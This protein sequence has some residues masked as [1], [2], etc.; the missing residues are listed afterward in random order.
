MRPDG[1]G[2]QFFDLVEVDWKSDRDNVASAG[3]SSGCTV[4]ATG[5]MCTAGL[6]AGAMAAGGRPGARAGNTGQA[7]RD[8]RII[9]MT[10]G[11]AGR[12]AGPIAWGIMVPES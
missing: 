11:L 8:G 10:S 12:A 6:A 4:G 1:G 5:A 2:V 9:G 7:R 3:T